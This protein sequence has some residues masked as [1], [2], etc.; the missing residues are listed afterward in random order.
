MLR[1][2]WRIL[3]RRFLHGPP[4]SVCHGPDGGRSLH[5]HGRVLCRVGPGNA[6]SWPRCIK[7]KNWL[8]FKQLNFYRLHKLRT[9]L[10]LL[11]ISSTSLLGTSVNRKNCVLVVF[12]IIN[13]KFTTFSPINRTDYYNNITIRIPVQF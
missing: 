8:L 5:A 3:G 4:C 12:L 1:Q 7:R 10:C 13:S 9:Y 6:G 11:Q 2:R